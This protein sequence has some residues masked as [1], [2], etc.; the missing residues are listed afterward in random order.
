MLFTDKYK[1]KELEHWEKIET[2]INQ[3]IWFTEFEKEMEDIETKDEMKRG[4]GRPRKNKANDDIEIT[5]D[6]THALLANMT[7]LRAP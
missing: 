6:D 1:S 3:N 4:R 7:V 5:D 2:E